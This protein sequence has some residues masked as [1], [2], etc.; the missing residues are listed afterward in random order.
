M[1]EFESH[2]EN[3]WTSLTK[4]TIKNYILKTIN[5]TYIIDRDLRKDSFNIIKNR[6]MFHDVTKLE[7]KFQFQ[8]T[9]KF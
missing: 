5:F 9:I 6:D 8:K 2:H 4:F 7:M 3:I 1:I